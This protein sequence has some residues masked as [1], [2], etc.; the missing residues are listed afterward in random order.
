MTYNQLGF[1]FTGLRTVSFATIDS[2]HKKSGETNIITALSFG[3]DIEHYT[4]TCIARFSFE[5][6]KDQP[7]LLLEVQSLFEIDENDFLTKVKQKDNSYLIAK[8]LAIHFA[9]LTVGAARGILH[10]KTE[11]T[12]YNAYLLPTIDLN[13]LVLDDVLLSTKQFSKEN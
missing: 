9:V 2:A 3:L 5:K 12:M 6:K 8:G 4:I 10:A 13:Q 7:F 11:N 1:A